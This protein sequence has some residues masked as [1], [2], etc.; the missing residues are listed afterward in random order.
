MIRIALLAL[1]SCSVAPNAFA[2]DCKVA[3]VDCYT[4]ARA[5]VANYTVKNCPTIFRIKTAMQI[6]LDQILNA[7][8]DAGEL[9]DLQPSNETVEQCEQRAK[10]YMAGPQTVR[11]MELTPSAKERLGI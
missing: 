8:R 5:V 1:F 9:A 3:G 10:E 11:F 7:L 6:E 4:A 2:N